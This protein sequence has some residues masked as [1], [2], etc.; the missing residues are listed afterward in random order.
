MF[1]GCKTVENISKSDLE[2][3]DDE[4]LNIIRQKL[5][6][7]VLNTSD[8]YFSDYAYLVLQLIDE[9][10]WGELSLITDKIFYNSYV[11]ESNGT[12]VDY[13]MFMLHTADKGLSTNYSLNEVEKAFYT[14]T[15]E[16][17]N[18]L[19]YEGIYLY[20]TGETEYFKIVIKDDGNGL[21]LSRE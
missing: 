11:V 18:G 7:H 3:V 2:V 8:P 14:G 16:I 4:N 1:L 9:K 17:E 15:I 20:P 10:N 6:E 13:C 12:L 5:S 21:I 19:I